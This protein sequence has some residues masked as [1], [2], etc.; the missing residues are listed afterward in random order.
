MTRS[1]AMR[2]QASATST[3]Y[4]PDG[5]VHLAQAV[6]STGELSDQELYEALERAV[7]I[8]LPPNRREI[9]YG[10]AWQGVP[11]H[12]LAHE[13]DPSASRWRPGN[14]LPAPDR[15]WGDWS[16][17]SFKEHVASTN[18]EPDR[19]RL[20]A[21]LFTGRPGRTVRRVVRAALQET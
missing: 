13:G 18:G 20:A 15:R 11:L 19:D 6:R 16:I 5:V 4:R 2:S 10:I 3:D 1:K 17:N 14:V 7:G 21:E 9:V 8:T 12:Y